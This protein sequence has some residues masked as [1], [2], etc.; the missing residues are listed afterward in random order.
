MNTLFSTIGRL[1]LLLV[2]LTYGIACTK[3]FEDY[4]T[5]PNKVTE[6]QLKGDGQDVGSFFPNMQ[7]SIMRV[8]DWE[9]QTQQNLNADAYSGYMASRN[10]FIGGKNNLTYSMVPSWNTTAFDLGYSN[11]MSNWLVIKQ[12]AETVKPDFYAVAT[13][14]KVASIQRVTDLY[15]PLPYTRYGEGGFTAEYDAQDKIYAAFFEELTK[16]AAVL[17][18]YVK[19]HPGAKPFQNFD[20]LFDGDYIKWVQFANTLKLRLAMRLTYVD[21]TTAKQK[22]EEAVAAENGLLAGEGVYVHQ[23]NGT[24]YM[25]PLASISNSWTDINMGAPMESYLVGYKDPR[26]GKYFTTSIESTNGY[27]GIR[28]GINIVATDDYKSFSYLNIKNED[29]MRLMSGAESYFLRAEGALR[30]WNMGGTPQA[31]YETG[32]KASF[33]EAGA[34]ASE[35]YVQDNTSKPA[36]YIDPKNNANNAN[37]PTT[38]TIKWEETAA[39]EQKLE[40][41]ITQKWIAL[42]PDG[43]EAWSEFRR[44]GY[45]KLFPVIVNFSGGTIPAGTYVKRLPFPQSELSNNTAAVAK[46]VQLLGGADNGGTRLWWDKK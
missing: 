16:A 10:P 31:L 24:T 34:G 39:F 32:I 18:A 9:Y 25:N 44:T 19:E 23:V 30:G 40:R 15:G 26:L 20:L 46:A 13:I 12:R 45:P 22:A 43:Q 3:N 6:D 4:N 29:L 1:F 2:V 21:A 11:V 5:D 33:A 8:V 38:I 14:L 17:S 7:T 35:T 41:I 37:A 27:K 42:Y 28:N 36:A